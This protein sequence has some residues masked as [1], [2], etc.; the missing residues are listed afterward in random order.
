MVSKD[1]TLVLLLLET[2][3]D[4][5]EEAGG[6][7]ERVGMILYGV[8]WVDAL[9]NTDNLQIRAS[10]RRRTHSAASASTR[11]VLIS[12]LPSDPA[13]VVNSTEAQA[14]SDDQNP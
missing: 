6:S 3:Q 14:R 7:S 5:E 8:W 4:T 12:G 11:S 1:E 9:I 13:A 2:E 10:S